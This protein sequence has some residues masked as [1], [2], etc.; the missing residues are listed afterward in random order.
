MMMCAPP[1]LTEYQNGVSDPADWYG[2]G[3]RYLH[4]HDVFCIFRMETS[5]VW[6]CSA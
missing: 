6:L 1:A 2:V 4:R 3:Y 5:S